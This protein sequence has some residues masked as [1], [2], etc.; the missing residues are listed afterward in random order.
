MKY[1]FLIGLVLLAIFII[2]FLVALV[3]SV[4]F[5]SIVGLG[6]LIWK[7]TFP[8]ITVML[9]I[10]SFIKGD[11][12]FFL[13]GEFALVSFEM[14]LFVL[15]E[16]RRQKI[17][18]WRSGYN[19]D[20]INVDKVFIDAIEK[21][22]GEDVAGYTYKNM[23]YGRADAFI[24]YF[25]NWDI[26]DEYYFF[27]PKRTSD[28]YKMRENGMLIAKS[29]IYVASEKEGKDVFQCLKFKDIYEYD[30]EKRTIKLISTSED[31]F[32]KKKLLDIEVVNTG[33]IE[34]V[35][36]ILDEVCKNKIPQYLSTY[37]LKDN[38]FYE[39]KIYS[40]KSAF[41]KAAVDASIQASSNNRNTILSENKSYMDG[42]QG[43]GYAAEYANLTIDRMLHKDVVNE[44]QNLDPN[45][46]RQI[47]NG[48]DRIVNGEYIQT[49]YVEDFQTLWRDG[50]ANGKGRYFHDGELMP[51]EVARDRYSD[52]KNQLQKKIDNG[53]F[54]AVEPGTDAGKYLRKGYVTYRQSQ[55]IAMAG[56]VEG[57][58]IDTANG[59]MCS[60]EA[61]TISSIIVFAQ[62]VWSGSDIDEAAKASFEVFLESVG[63][64]TAIFVLT[65]QLI[66]KNA[67]IPLVNV[68]TDNSIAYLADNIVNELKNSDFA[69]TSVGQALGVDKLTKRK[70]I[71][72]T[73]AAVIYF[74][75]D[76]YKYFQGRISG[77]QL[78]KNATS[79][80]AGMAA[81]AKAGATFGIVGAVAGGILGSMATKK[82][83][84]NF[85]IDDAKEMFVIF[86]EEFID[87]ITISQLSKEE[88]TQITEWT[89]NNEDFSNFL[90]IMYSKENPRLFA[91][92]YLSELVQQI[93]SSREPITKEMIE[94]GYT[95]LCGNNSVVNEN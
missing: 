24:N 65:Q 68:T 85:I 36:A 39:E 83:L 69:K 80:A 29:G 67:K 21:N 58:V 78:F 62:A 48:A 70:L 50:F 37:S 32:T 56:T 64:N 35:S 27:L 13:Y 51:I 43:H 44:A 86:K 90:E 77:K 93:Y 95:L 42:R 38:I 91:R 26:N 40:D 92:I 75:P 73:V 12:T 76:V 25:S 54:P 19:G 20:A 66:R 46:G 28:I 23:P 6:A 7:F 2:I 49:K 53:D 4:F 63:K 52:M 74:G 84:D 8:T 5:Y 81:G 3:V 57:I 47:A 10:A 16:L 34:K 82:I 60:L 72:G 88:F 87:V 71:S 1:L 79:T 59:V 94:E 45:T 9:A 33:N 11:L 22:Y 14:L 55:N 18:K 17:K 31:G 41:R 30:H 89:I 61:A 15:E